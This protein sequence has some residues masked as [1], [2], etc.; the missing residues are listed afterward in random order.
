MI[1]FT[2]GCF[3][4]DIFALFPDSFFFETK[5]FDFIIFFSSWMVQKIKHDIF[6]FVFWSRCDFSFAYFDF[7]L[8]KIAFTFKRNVELSPGLYM[9]CLF[10]CKVTVRRILLRLTLSLISYAVHIVLLWNRFIR[11][12]F[13]YT[14]VTL[15]FQMNE[16]TESVNNDFV[17]LTFWNLYERANNDLRRCE[18]VLGCFC[19]HI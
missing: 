11:L 4:L 18:E 19:C 8:P 17:L 10:D 6:V 14:N 1:A 7:F 13:L 9:N 15:N 3:F 5:T 12:C 16:T 2:V